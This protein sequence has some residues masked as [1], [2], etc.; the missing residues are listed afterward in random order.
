MKSISEQ[1]EMLSD[2]QI[3]QGLVKPNTAARRSAVNPK[4]L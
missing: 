2:I 4:D 3:P 1:H